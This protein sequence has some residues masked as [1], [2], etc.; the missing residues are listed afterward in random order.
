VAGT[1]ENR[2][3]RGA[4]GGDEFRRPSFTST[5]VGL[6]L[7]D[8]KIDNLDTP[9]TTYLP[10]LTRTAC[11]DAPGGRWVYRSIDTAVL[12]MLVNRVTGQPLA[13][14]LSEKIWQPLGMEQDATWLT[15]RP[16]GLEAADCC[17]NATLRAYGRFGFMMLHHGKAGP[18]PGLKRRSKM[19]WTRKKGG[20]DIPPFSISRRNSLTPPLTPA[21]PCSWAPERPTQPSATSRWRARPRR[22]AAPSPWSAGLP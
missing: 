1:N 5:L 22:R 11:E 13:T 12:G 9:I 8:R 7:T 16:D 18:L 3:P 4:A 2:H 10:E 15:D 21:H 19:K 6:A 20:I 14:M 17:F